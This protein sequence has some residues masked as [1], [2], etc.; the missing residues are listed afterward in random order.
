MGVINKLDIKCGNSPIVSTTIGLADTNDAG[1]NAI[2]AT[3]NPI[4]GT[5]VYSHTSTGGIV[6]SILDILNN[7][8]GCNAYLYKDGRAVS[9][10]GTCCISID[11]EALISGDLDNTL[12]IGTDGK[13]IVKKDYDVVTELK[14]ITNGFTYKNELGDD[15]PVT[16]VVVGSNMEVKLDG[17]TVATIPLNLNEIQIDNAGSDFNLADD[18]LTFLETN[19]DSATISFAKYNVTATANPNGSTTISQN[20]VALATIPATHPAATLTNNNAPFSWNSATQTGNI[21]TVKITANAN[22]HLVDLG[23][24]STPVQINDD[25]TEAAMTINGTVFPAGTTFEAILAAL[26][27]LAHVPAVVTNN[28]APYAWN[29]TTQTLNIPQVPSIV[30]GQLVQG[31]GTPAE[32]I[33]D[34]WRVGL[35]ATGALPDGTTDVTDVIA[36]QSDIFVGLDAL[37]RVGHGAG[38]LP[39]NTAVGNSTLNANTTGGSNVAIGFDTLRSNTTGGNNVGIGR[40]S[41][42]SNTTGGNNIAIGRDSLFANTTGSSNT[43]NGYGALAANTTGGFNVAIGRDSMFRNTTGANNA[44]AGYR[45]MYSNT[46]GNGNS[47]YGADSL[48]SNTTGLNNTAIGYLSGFSSVG[49]NNATFVGNQAGRYSVAAGFSNNTYIGQWSG[50]DNV[51]DGQNSFLGQ[52]SGQFSLGGSNTYLGQATGKNHRNGSQN[53]AVGQSANQNAEGSNNVTIGKQAALLNK[54]NNNTFV[55]FDSQNIL[56]GESIASATASTTTQIT[57]VTPTTAPVGSVVNLTFTTNTIVGSINQSDSWLVVNPTTLESINKVEPMST[58]GTMSGL[59]LTFTTRNYSNSST[60]GATSRVYSDNQ[61]ALGNNLVTTTVFG[62]KVAFDLVAINAAPIGTTLKI[63]G[64]AVG[65][66]TGVVKVIG[67]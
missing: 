63:T 25:N 60:L 30:N 15:V 23:D 43:A 36:H 20:G 2:L 31:D 7:N 47:A 65:G 8:A 56:T 42:Y 44:G 52:S 50:G 29:A 41:L 10:Q 39:S 49:Q 32:Q 51:N 6:T 62:D 37:M 5:Y 14:P 22:G 54:G 38:N 33:P 17:T 66:H 53:T 40:D 24:G 57:L 48:Y 35:G 9:S 46:T 4:Y 67:V 1:I 27:T 19:G 59:S 58:T 45:S 3:I 64:T 13:L 18:S 12:E 16:Y 61:V 55:G 34:F 28:A 11:P 26:S 21:P